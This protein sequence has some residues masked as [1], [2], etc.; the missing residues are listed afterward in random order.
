MDHSQDISKGDT[1]ISVNGGCSYLSKKQSDI[2]NHILILDPK[3]KKESKYIDISNHKKDYLFQIEEAYGFREMD[4]NKFFVTGTNGKTTTVHLLSQMLFFSNNS[5]ASS[6][7]LG[8]FL[9]NQFQKAQRLTTETP[10][11]IRNFLHDCFSNK[12]ENILFEASSIGLQENRLTGLTVDHAALSNI[13]RDHLDYHGTFAN[14]V[15][16]KIE[17]ARLCKGTF[18]YVKEDEISDLINKSFHGNK[19]YSAAINDARA[20]INL[21]IK[22]IYRDGMIDFHADTPWGSCQ[23]SVKLFADYNLLNLFLGLPYYMSCCDNIELFFEKIPELKLPTGR[24]QL[25]EKNNKK[26]FIDFAH[27]PQA[28]EKTLISIKKMKPKRII[29]VFGAGGERDQGKRNQM[30]EVAEKYADQLIITADNP[31]NENPK[32]ISE[33]IIKTLSKNSNYEVENNRKKAIKRA[34]ASLGVNEILLIAGKGHENYQI[35]EG[36]KEKFSDIEEV[37]RCLKLLD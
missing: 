36:R 7:T 6:G 13:S 37:K 11:Y 2:L 33:M 17:L 30:G 19:L 12:I 1:F 32:S 28:L 5:N 16:S 14:Y 35:I 25:F 23:N 10:I 22:K 4:F 27:T 26:I 24:L 31:R 29:L 15:S 8:I 20:D 18:T 3:E 34:F 9:N 21:S